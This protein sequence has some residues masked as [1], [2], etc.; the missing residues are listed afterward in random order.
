MMRTS[1]LKSRRGL[2]LRTCILLCCFFAAQAAV[3]ANGGYRIT[4]HRQS[5]SVVNALKE[6]ERQ[7]GLS[8]GYNASRLTG[9]NPIA[10][11]MDN[12]PL[13]QALSDIL[14]GT[15]FTFRIQE[16]YIMIVPVTEQ[17]SAEKKI[18]GKVTDE[19]GEPLI[20]VNIRVTKSDIGTVTD[21][22]GNFTLE[23]PVGS[24]L[25]ISYIGFETQTLRITEKGTYTVRLRASAELLS[26][27]VVTALGI[28]REQKALSYNVQQVGGEQLTDIKDANFINSL[29]GKVAGLV[30]NSSSSGVGGASKVVMR[31]AKSIMRSSNALYVVDGVPLYNFGGGGGTEFESKGETE[32]IADF[33]PED[34]ESISVL[35]GAAA[36]ALYG[37]NAANGAV[38]INTKKGKEGKA[39]LTLST[40]IDWTRPF[41]M[42]EFQNRY[43]TGSNGRADGSLTYSWGPELLPAARTGFEPKK[44]FIETGAVYTNSVSLSVGNDKNQTYASVATVNSDGMIPNNRYNRYNFTFRNTTL[45]LKDKMK[46]DVSGSYIMQNDRNMT[47]QGVY[48]NPLVPVYLFPR[49]DDFSL[50]K[51]F[52]RYDEGRKIPQQYWPAG[53]GDMRIQNPYWEAYRNLR[54][55]NKKRYMFSA[56]LSYDVTPWLNLTGR[57][58][59]DNSNTMFEQKLY[60]STITTL[61]SGTQ[62]HYTVSKFDEAQTYADFIAS[63]NKR[64]NDFSLSVNLGTSYSD[65]RYDELKVRGPIRD[66]GVPNKFDVFDLD[67]TKKST[68]QYGWEEGLQAIFANVELGWKSMLYLTLSGRN[69]WASQL[70][71]TENPS[72]PYGSAGLSWVLS[73]TFKLPKFIDFLKLRAAYSSVGAPYQRHL[74]SPTYAYDID[75]A[76]WSTATYYPMSELFPERTKSWEI[77]LEATLWKDL[78]LNVSFYHANTDKQTFDPRL[79][80]SSGYETI[81][82]QSGRVRNM[83]VELSLGYSHQWGHFGWDSNFTFSANRN[84]II[85]LLSNLRNPVT[86]EIVDLPELDMKGL[87]KAHFRLREGGTL[88]DLYSSSDL[89]RDENGKIMVDANGDIAVVDKENSFKLGSVFPKANLAWNNSFSWKNL[90]FSFLFT[91]RLGGIVYSATQAY[92]DLYGVS[93]TTALA[94]DN[95]GVWI[96]DGRSLVDAEKWYS[97]TAS[98]SG[99]PQLY[100]YS[101]TNVRLQEARIGYT[102]PRHWLGNVCSINVSLVGRNLWMLY[103]KAPFDPESTATTGNFYQGIDY[104]MMPSTRNIGFNVKIN[105]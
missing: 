103:C 5:I 55:N 56:S 50:I 82:V 34:I 87:G 94:R 71:G 2:R 86:G 15:G 67:K 99:I 32:G 29:N 57:V 77:G 42:P 1:I 98:Q 59:Q 75:K 93:E 14:T 66:N 97:K 83:G 90:D 65:T 63:F 20:G 13:E 26:E 10:V 22:E 37:S 76:Q 80:A 68:E 30:I 72:Y 100:T 11:S 54:T 79:P 102:L 24:I 88:G 4:M 19:N 84:K 51:V 89:Q 7:S 49:S 85:S 18:Q 101:A 6:V 16:N 61:A 58:R 17:S 48:F 36:A 31:G 41:V 25:S 62:G 43:G 60:A 8:V 38:V 46:F 91:A 3:L 64:W 39:K 69:E 28:K 45:F 78:R 81:Y 96:N 70:K 12:A 74:S 35:T 44:D 104:F 21:I 40:G 95:G 73:E 53:E 47:N 23:A 105:F 27:V 92:M 9:M 33:N 52:E